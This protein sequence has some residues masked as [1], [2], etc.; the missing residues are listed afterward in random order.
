MDTPKD[1][2]EKEGGKKNQA[3][4]KVKSPFRGELHFSGFMEVANTRS[5]VSR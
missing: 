5:G 2:K 1:G 4:N 3:L